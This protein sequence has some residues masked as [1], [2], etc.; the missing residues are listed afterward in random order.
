M[1]L[2]IAVIIGAAFGRTVYTQIIRSPLIS[3]PL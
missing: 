1:D 2:A 3:Y